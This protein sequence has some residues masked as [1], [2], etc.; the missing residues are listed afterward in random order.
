MQAPRFWPLSFMLILAC[1]SERHSV[2][3][4][5]AEP[6]AAPRPGSEQPSASNGVD[7]PAVA[8]EQSDGAAR[9]EEQGSP[10][11]VKIIEYVTFR[12]TRDDPGCGDCV[13]LAASQIAV[14][15]SSFLRPENRYGP[16]KL[17]DGDM[18]TA[19]CEGAEGDGTGEWVALEFA[20][21][22][23]VDNILLHPGYLKSDATLFANG[24]PTT[25]LVDI[26]GRASY[27]VELPEYPTDYASSSSYVYP[28]IELDGS[29]IQRIRIT[30]ENVSAGRAAR[31]TC[32]SGVR[33]EVLEE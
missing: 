33:I 7:V 27:R 3:A 24:R 5:P 6:V 16:S 30:L 32:I 17:V 15:A 1:S 12:P 19:W 25:L 4:T 14:S 2:S 21:P 29:R 20:Q 23:P 9:N 22:L 18:Q 10:D 31:D 8:N 13:A 26:D 11:A 28:T